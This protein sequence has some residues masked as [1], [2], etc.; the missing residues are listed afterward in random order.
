MSAPNNDFDRCRSHPWIRTRSRRWWRGVRGVRSRDDRGRA[1]EAGWPI[2]GE[3]HRSRWPTGDRCAAAPARK[4]AGCVRQARARIAAALS[5]REAEIAEAEMGRIWSRSGSR[6]CPC[7]PC[8]GAPSIPPPADVSDGRVFVAMGWEVAEGPELEADGLNFDAL[9]F[10]PDH[11]ARTHSKTPCLS[12][13]TM[14]VWCCG[15]HTSPSRAAPC[16]TREPP[17]YVVCHGRV[18]RADEYDATIC[19]SSTRSRVLVRR[20]GHHPRHLRG[21]LDHFADHV[22]E[23]ADP[24]AAQILPVSP[25]RRP[26]STWSLRLPRR[27]RRQPDVPAGVQARRVDRVGGCGVVNP[28]VLQAC[29]VDSGCTPGS[30]F[31]MGIDPHLMSQQRRG[32]ARMIEGDLR[33]S[34]SLSDWRDEGPTE[35]LR[36]YAPARGDGRPQ[37]GRLR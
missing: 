24:D 15:P 29:G 16:W 5:A 1:E 21:T 36:E 8:R 30:R 28:R 35:R 31:G 33:F 19:R 26:R 25:S 23:D 34:R 12:N 14:A 13:P 18:Y 11:P 6:Q 2:A 17:I 27:L 3:R 4:E 32:H 22:R 9:N 10:I 7:R 37:P 20:P